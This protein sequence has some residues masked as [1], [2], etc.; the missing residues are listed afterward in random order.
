MKHAIQGLL[1]LCAL[2]LAFGCKPP[3]EDADKDKG[4]E[5]V[6]AKV[7]LDFHIM[8][9]CPYGVKVLQAITPVLEKMG[10]RIDFKVHFIGNEKNGELT[11]MHGEE[12]VKG[13]I[14]HLCANEI[15]D[16]ASWLAFMK[17]QN[18]DWKKI[19]K[20]WEEC[21]K[22]AKLDEA[23]MKSCYEGEQGK[24]LLK[25]SFKKSSDK[26]ATGS[27]TIFLAGEPYKGGRSEVY[28]G[29]AICRVMKEPKAGYCKD[30]PEAVKFAVTV[31]N[32]NRCTG[33]NCDSKRFVNYIK[34][35]F[36][37]AEVTELD[38]ADAEGKKAYERSGQ[39]FVPLAIFSPEIKKDEG[40]KRLKRRLKEVPE[41]EDLVYVIGRATWD[42][43]AEICDDGKDNTGN[44]QVD[45]DDETCKST[46]A[47]REEVKNK[48]DLFIMSQC[49]YGVRAVDAM[50][51][52]LDNFD[53]NRKLVDFELQYIGQENDGQF[54]SLHG[55]P[56]VDEDIRQLCAQKIYKKNYKFMDYVLC[57]N[58]DYRSSDWESCATGGISAAAIKKCA[59][60]DEGKQLLSASFKLA[61]DLGVRGSPNWLLN[62]KLEMRAR[63]PEAIK[64]EFCKAN[65]GLK[66]CEN[67]LSG[68]TKAAPAGGCGAPPPKPTAKK[69][70]P[71][72]PGAKKAE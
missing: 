64:R 40:Y 8:S 45:C 2:V 12:E 57:R 42:P 60:G 33:R 25:A 4:K 29:R 41:S 38:Y 72:P 44:G 65:E 36:E 21:A 68:D 49:P 19:P 66:G 43:T 71:P 3:S 51:E 34:E 69:V 46:R 70:V 9:K 13:D 59:E 28:F 50:K 6:G 39:T 52:V 58:K 37:G 54:S 24:N 67:T 20:G 18:E 5:P 30:I 15:G 35:T 27:P 22:K 10:D 17:C 26:K 23:K 31:V 11:S 56:E 32:D 7:A 48:L 62:N 53:K 47:C 61:S 14:L 63:S 16:Q 55:P 1:V